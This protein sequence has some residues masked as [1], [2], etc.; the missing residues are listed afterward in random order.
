M[1]SLIS[2]QYKELLQDFHS[3][4]PQWGA[5]SVRFLLRI[6]NLIGDYNIA[7]VLDYGCGKAAIKKDIEKAYPKTHIQLYD[8]GIPEHVNL[9]E[10]ADLVI[11]TDV[12]EH[13]EEEFI[14]GVLFH[15]ACLTK[16]VAYFVVHTGDC[17]HRLP[18]G[19]PAHILQRNQSWW[20]EKFAQ[21]FSKFD[22]TYKDTA[23]PMRFE[24]IMVRD[25]G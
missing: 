17:G 25:N 13:V 4:N 19:R 2:P 8:P 12:L 14:D 21:N 7:S 1:D 18:D 16:K 10:C 6:L 15:I 5:S 9:P 24:A 22:I 23:L 3:S 11:C 20:Q